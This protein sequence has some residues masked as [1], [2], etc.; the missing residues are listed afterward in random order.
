MKLIIFCQIFS[1][2]KGICFEIIQSK[3][4]TEDNITYLIKFAK[5]NGGIDYTYSVLEKITERA[6][7]MVSQMD[8]ETVGLK[9]SFLSV[10]QYLKQ[11]KY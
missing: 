1:T 5:N 10:I 4:F 8:F 3:D 6:N 11:R 2:I 9:E 7:Q